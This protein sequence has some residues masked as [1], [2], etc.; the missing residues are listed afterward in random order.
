[1]SGAVR[2][3]PGNSLPSIKFR[4]PPQPARGRI[5]HKTQKMTDTT[6]TPIDELGSD[7]IAALRHRRT[8]AGSS[9]TKVFLSGGAA[10]MALQIEGTVPPFLHFDKPVL[11]VSDADAL[12]LEALDARCKA[13]AAQQLPGVDWR[14]LVTPTEHGLQIQ[15]GKID[16]SARI[17]QMQEDGST[18][19]LGTY[20]NLGAGQLMSKSVVFTVEIDALT[21]VSR[22]R[23]GE[24]VSL[25]MG[26]LAC[27]VLP[28]DKQEASRQAR[29]EA[30]AKARERKRERAADF[31]RHAKRFK[32]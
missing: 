5:P 10:E 26:V 21:R 19:L 18:Q 15:L 9:C 20:G 13:I 32:K 16:H 27:L 22:Q 1:M 2:V 12:E 23:G 6:P 4:T 17:V 11:V 8:W 28:T 30:A 7:A 25:T 3:G 31:S 29:E 14:P 24:D